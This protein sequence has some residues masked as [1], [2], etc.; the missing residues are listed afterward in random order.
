MGCSY[1]VKSYWAFSFDIEK[2]NS[3][4]NIDFV[5]YVSM[6]EAMLFFLL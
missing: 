6:S 4:D 5:N 1:S 2:D 3:G